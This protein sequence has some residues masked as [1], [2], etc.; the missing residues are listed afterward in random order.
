MMRYKS[1][2]TNDLEMVETLLKAV[3]KGL[4]NSTINPEDAYNKVSEALIRLDNAMEKVR[5][6]PDQ[7]S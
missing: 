4:N 1:I 6:E 7:H 5:L 3:Q 2:V